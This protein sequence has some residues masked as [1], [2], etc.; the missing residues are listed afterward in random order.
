MM[1]DVE[2]EV[3]VMEMQVLLELL[4]QQL[5]RFELLG[6]GSWQLKLGDRV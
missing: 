2:L 1:Q 4:C 5:R 3:G 6:L